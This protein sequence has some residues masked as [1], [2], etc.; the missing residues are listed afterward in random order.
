[1][2][3]KFKLLSYLLFF[4]MISSLLLLNI[5]GASEDSIDIGDINHSVLFSSSY[6]PDYTLYSIASGNSTT[7][8]TTDGTPFNAIIDETIMPDD[9]IN[10]Y[11]NEAK[12]GEYGITDDDIEGDPSYSYNCH[13]F[14]WYNRS[15]SNE[16][17]INLP[18]QFIED[19]HCSDELT[20]SQLQPGDIATYWSTGW[21]ADNDGNSCYGYHCAHSAVIESI[22]Y[23]VDG[24]I[25]TCK[26]K[27]G[28][29]GLYIH[30]LYAVP[31]DTSDIQYY[32]Y[33]Q[34]EHETTYTSVDSYRHIEGCGKCEYTEYVEH[35]TTYTSVDS[36][37]HVI[38]C[39]RCQYTEYVEHNNNCMTVST[40]QH[41]YTCRDC[42]FSRS[43]AHT[44]QYTEY[45]DQEHT[46]RCSG[47]GY[48]V[49]EDHDIYIAEV[50]NHVYTIKC[51]GCTYEISCNCDREYEA[52]GD[53]GHYVEC[54][55]GCFSE[56]ESH[57]YELTGAYNSSGHEIECIYCYY[58]EYVDHDLYMYSAAYEDYVVKCYDCNY[59]VECWESPEYGEYS[60]EEHWIGCPCGCYSFY[61]PHT[62]GS[63]TDIDEP[64]HEVVCADCG[65]TYYEEHNYGSCYYT[66]SANY[67]YY[68]CV[69]CGY[70]YAEQHLYR[71]EIETGN[72]FS[73]IIECTICGFDSTEAHT[74]V[75][76]GL[77]YRCTVCGM[78]SDA[79]P[80]I[81]SLPNPEL[82]AY[83]ASLSGEELEEFI[84]SLPEDQ[85]AHVTALLPS[86]DEHLTE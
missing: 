1:M 18:N 26:S 61:E 73:H 51:R 44:P 20:K 50:Y 72:L 47:C 82:E 24:D 85:V 17:W 80:G 32:R 66:T 69:D 12:S 52:D 56:F 9:K 22:E 21:Y 59:T 41:R 49:Y 45:S 63:Y 38:G 58:S 33:T 7:L 62:P 40:T 6:N 43:E 70:T 35:E 29:G 68:E 4:V 55:D 23:D 27:W 8:L 57:T 78:L 2:K 76:A 30:D 46:V 77:G 14:A 34:G 60:N 65:D 16:Y 74:W 36:Y 84:A 79:I 10:E 25:I 53:M 13:S 71:S 67:H 86:D 31:Y 42:G 83:L 11:N 54:M 48:T 15:T 37:R 19:V 3:N 81:M 39:G 64:S 5:Y 28:P 75:S